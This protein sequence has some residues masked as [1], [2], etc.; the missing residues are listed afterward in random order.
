MR[1][2]TVVMGEPTSS[3]RNS[4]TTSMLDYGFNT[5]KVDSLVSRDTV[6]DTKKVSLGKKRTVKI[7]PKEDVNVLNE[8][9]STKRNVTYKADV[10]DIKAPIK[11]GDVV[12]KIK[13]IEN[14]NIIMTVDATVK[15]NVDKAS[16][17]TAYIRELFDMIKGI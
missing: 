16:F 17:I 10:N 13:V 9:A 6:V 12:G 3:V 8:K 14:N 7:V 1:L 2:I 11:S 4:D 5:Y 15:D